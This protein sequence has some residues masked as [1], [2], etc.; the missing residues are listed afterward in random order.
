MNKKKLLIYIVLSILT[1]SVFF[2]ISFKYIYNKEQRLLKN[3]YE[4]LAKQVIKN[5]DFLI[6]DKKK[7]HSIFCNS[8]IKI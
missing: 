6:E 3:N 7:C 4:I 5:I 1:L 8:L 2:V